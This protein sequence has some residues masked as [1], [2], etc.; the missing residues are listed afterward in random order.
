MPTCPSCSREFP[1]NSR[2]CSSCGSSVALDPASAETAVVT[3]PGPP[4]SDPS[5]IHGRFEPGT[6]LGNRYRIVGLLGRGG[7]GEVYRA[8][9]LELGQSVA[10]KFLPERVAQNPESLAR[11]RNEVR[12]ARQV[13]H[14]NVCRIHDIGEV[15]GHVF[16]SMEHIDG[17]DLASVLRRMGRPT[18]DKALEIARQLCMGLAA[19]HENGILHRDLKPA[20]VMIDGRGRVRITDFGLAGLTE[21]LGEGGEVA[22]TPAYMAPEQLASGAVSV[23]SDVYSLGLILFEVFSGKRAYEA[24]SLAEL[25]SLHQSGSVSSPSSHVDDMDPA[26]ERVVLRCLEN[27]PQD[28]PQSV[29]SVLG[30]LPGADP[31]AAALAAGET[32]SPELVANAE[33]TG[34]LRPRVAIACVAFILLT[35]IAF[36]FFSRSSDAL[37]GSQPPEVLA[38]R[39]V[40]VL[41][42]AGYEDLPEFSLSGLIR[43]D[44]YLEHLADENATRTRWD[45][46]GE[47][48]SPAVVFFR[49]WSP[50]GLGSA[51]LHDPRVTPYNPPQI[52]PGAATVLMD[53][54][55]R[56]LGL[57]VVPIETDEPSLAPEPDWA[58]LFSAAGLEIERFAP[59]TP[60]GWRGTD[61]SGTELTVEVGAHLGRPVHFAV[62]R[63]WGEVT[64]AR[65]A[66]SGLPSGL[67][68]LLFVVN[69]IA[70]VAGIFLA[71]RNVRLGRGDRRG[72]FRLALFTVAVYLIESLF[73]YRLGSDG[74]VGLWFDVVTGNMMGHAL[75]H[76]CTIWVFYLALEP[77]VRRLWPR[78]LVSW[79]RVLS[80]RLRDPLI[81]RDLLVGGVYAVGT[82]WLASLGVVGLSFTDSPMPPPV[83]SAEGLMAMLG[84]RGLAHQLA[85]TVSRSIVIV[86]PVFVMLLAFRMV[87]RRTWAAAIACIAVYGAFVGQF[88]TAEMYSLPVSFVVA[89]VWAACTI[90][91]LLRFGLLATLAGLYLHFILTWLPW[92]LDLSSWWSSNFLIGLLAFLLVIGYGFYVSLGGR[93]IFGDMLKEPATAARS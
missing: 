43:N 56:L 8:D 75:V 49:R 4:L 46:I 66:G 47:N 48:G 53:P 29:Y 21:Q 86:M 54:H 63:D 1:E 84:N 26:V 2:F 71:R 18:K 73:L 77:Y 36:A 11:F 83:P 13:T 12:L 42:H 9:D 31:L 67:G 14:P 45:G 33:E 16:L 3:T 27:A 34:A 52:L 72:A 20:N 58:A 87:L 79:A 10:L 28:R 22:G 74:L 82:I 69:S 90:T 51:E 68:V 38:V 23:R 81:G 78:A 35:L 88:L 93:S 37:D 62:V 80:G 85:S 40:D 76:G 44:A 30:A 59:D 65:P 50:E 70:V 64:D 25:K 24:S 32:P 61:A 15:A 89:G 41:R 5:S 60:Y 39:A 17:E 57:D 19:A 92:T 7:M 6:K 55:G 91:V